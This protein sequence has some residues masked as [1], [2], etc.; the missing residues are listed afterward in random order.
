[1]PLDLPH[2]PRRLRRTDALRAM[3]RETAVAPAHLVH[4]LFIQDGA[5]S[6]AI[7]AMPGCLR[8]SVDDLVREA[9][10]SYALGI[11]AV[12]LFPKVPDAKKTADGKE[13]WN[14]KGLVPRAVRALKKEL[15][16]LCVITDIALDPYNSDG[17][18]GLVSNDGEILNDK[19]VALLCKQALAHAEAGADIIAPSDMMDGRVGALRK[20]L[21]GAG[22]ESVG[23]L[24]YAAKYA[25][26]FY[27]PFRDAL[28]SAP[29]AAGKK[30]IPKDKKTYQMDPANA[31]EAVREAQL[32]E[33]EGAD[34][35]MVKPAGAYLDILCRLRQA[36]TLPLAAYQVSGEFAMIKHAA[37]AGA[38]KEE[39]AALESLLAIRRAG[40]D[41][42]FTYFAPQAAKWLA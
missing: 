10:K 31:R 25:S 13:A 4:P 9:A 35:L 23:I 18:D 14:P 36:T 34:M 11:R 2:R 40:A 1:M 22:A 17:H 8:L 24:S 3:V 42:I 5:K 26:A 28:D 30:P 19:T 6:E 27:G 41:L 7:A 12:A 21:D 37:A 16:E 29:R 38:V 33:A 15:P 39:A 32:D 20:G